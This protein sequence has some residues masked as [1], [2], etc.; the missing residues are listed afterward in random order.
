MRARDCELLLEMHSDSLHSDSLEVG[1]L[2]SSAQGKAIRES[3]SANTQPN[4]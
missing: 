1:Q 4:G 2:V 3:L